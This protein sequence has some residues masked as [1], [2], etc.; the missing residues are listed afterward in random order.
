MML[1][2]VVAIVIMSGGPVVSKLF[3]ANSIAKPVVFHVHGF[4]FFHNIIVHYAEG[5]GVIRLDWCWWLRVP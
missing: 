2:D 4:E 5:G 3:L 1:S